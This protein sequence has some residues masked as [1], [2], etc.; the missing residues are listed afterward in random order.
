[1]PFIGSLSGGS[2]TGGTSPITFTPGS[3][4]SGLASG[5]NTDSMVQ[6]L[7]TAAQVPLV[8]LLQQRQVLQW[9]ETRYQQ[10]NASLSTLQNSVQSMQLQS[11]FMANTATSSNSSIVTATASTLV[12]QGNYSVTVQQLAQGS[13]IFSSS[14][15]NTTDTNYPSDTTLSSLGYSSGVNLT[16]NGQAFSFQGTDTLQTVLAQINGTTATGVSGFFDSGSGNFVFQTSSTGGQASINVDSTTASFFQ[17]AFNVNTAP[18]LTGTVSVPSTGLSSPVTIEINGQNMQLSGTLSNIETTIDSYQ[19]TTGV[20]ASDNG[21]NLILNSTST[22]TSGSTN[23][24]LSLISV[25]DPT[26][27]LGFKSPYSGNAAQQVA[28]DAQYTVNGM[29]ETSSTNEATYNGLSLNLLSTS[30]TPVQ[31]GV[32]VDASTIAESITNFVQQYN[33]TLQLMQGL[34]NEKSNSSYQPL[35]TTQ[36]SQMTQ[37]QI[38]QWNEQAQAG[39]LENDPTLGGIMNTLENDMQNVVSGQSQSTV[40]GQTTTLNSLASIGISPID[41]LNGLSSGAEAPGVT[42]SGWNSYGLL[43]INPTQLQAAIQADPQ[44]VMNLFTNNPALPGS[45]PNVGMG[46]ATQLYND[47]NTA[48]QTLTQQA[49]SNPNVNSLIQTTTSSGAIVAG[50][51]L[52]QAT[53]ID[54]NANFTTLFATDTLDVSFIGQQLNN[55][56]SQA[57]SMQQQLTNLQQRYQ[58][59]FSQMEQSLS[60]TNSQSGGLTAMLGGGSSSSSSSSG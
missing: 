35:T 13:T 4:I 37:T 18:S 44:A 54:A 32:S 11:T 57:T 23:Q 21:T 5:I 55:M 46:I 24:L 17:K 34:Y 38:D 31:I 36:A 58:S 30:S 7:M 15:V 19:A 47:L 45:D 25:S 12:P 42:T 39:V 28:Q 41:P 20:T 26:N 33:Q 43:Q 1:M 50:A 10:V 48:T 27:A 59:E 56:D 52:M 2:S 49:G 40:N 51:G 22:G 60:Q 14:P 8:Q 3:G 53:P 29:S 16:I 9:Q 6:G